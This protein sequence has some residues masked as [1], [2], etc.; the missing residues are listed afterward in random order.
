M[1]GLFGVFAITLTQA[2]CED[3]LSS[4]GS[5]SVPVNIPT[6]DKPGSIANNHG[7]SVVLTAADQDSAMD[8]AL[9]LTGGGHGHLL[10]LYGD[11][12]LAVATGGVAQATSLMVI[13]H[14]HLVTFGGA[15]QPATTNS[16]PV[17]PSAP[18]ADKTG[19]I[20]V[21]HGHTVVLTGAEQDAGKPVTL[22]LT[23]GSGHTHL[24]FLSASQVN[25][26]ASGALIGATTTV[27]LGHD[28]LITFQ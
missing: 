8:V 11:Q 25:D 21:N 5:T 17:T 18:H 6:S 16:V 13:G 24:L 15:V 23:T 2:G 26:A 7:H 20:S 3:G 27:V 1:L 22:S 28:H 12:V 4:G 19:T 14:D 9:R 10:Y